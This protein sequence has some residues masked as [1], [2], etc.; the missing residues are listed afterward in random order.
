M[1]FIHC[2]YQAGLNGLVSTGFTFYVK[3]EMMTC[4][5]SDR[6]GLRVSHKHAH[7]FNIELPGRGTD[8]AVNSTQRILH[9]RKYS[10]ARFRVKEISDTSALSLQSLDASLRRCSRPGGR[11]KTG[12]RHIRVF[13]F[14]YEMNLCT[15]V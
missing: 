4:R 14:I 13:S 1:D 7:Q 3:P 15:G 12:V 8:R 10:E 2:I 6:F 9:I 5:F 11:N